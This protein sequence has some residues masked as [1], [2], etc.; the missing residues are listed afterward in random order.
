MVEFMKENVLKDKMIFDDTDLD[1]NEIRIKS[2]NI[3]KAILKELKKDQKIQNRIENRLKK[4]K[5]DNINF[6][7][8]GNKGNLPKGL[9]K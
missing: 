6:G 1:L 2:N 5:E 7:T 9:K 3:D 4:Q 8:R